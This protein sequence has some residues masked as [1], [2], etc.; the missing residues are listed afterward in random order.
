MSETAP[1]Y[2]APPVRFPSL[3]ETRRHYAGTLHVYVAGPPSVGPSVY[4]ST[5]NE[6]YTAESVYRMSLLELKRL[7]LAHHF[8][9]G[10]EGRRE[11]HRLLKGH[12]G[13]LD[14]F[15]MY[16]SMSRREYASCV[17][18]PSRTMIA[19]QPVFGCASDA[20]FRG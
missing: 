8:M 20:W 4:R 10:G 18:T 19:L 9:A 13:D 12:E 11:I 17:E 14:T 5:Q 15:L 7:G 16:L 2:S 6:V 3:E 1:R